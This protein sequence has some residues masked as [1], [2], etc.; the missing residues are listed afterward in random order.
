MASTELGIGDKSINDSRVVIQSIVRGLRLFEV[1]GQTCARRFPS[2]NQASKDHAP[3]PTLIRNSKAI[4]IAKS[5]LAS[6]I[7]NQKP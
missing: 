4:V 7:M 6:L 5:V 2:Q 3:A 1:V